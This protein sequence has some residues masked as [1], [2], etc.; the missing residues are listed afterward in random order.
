MTKCTSQLLLDIT[1]YIALRMLLLGLMLRSF[2]VVSLPS[3]FLLPRTLVDSTIMRLPGAL[4]DHRMTRILVFWDQLAEHLVAKDP[5]VVNVFDGD[6]F[7]TRYP[8]L[9][10]CRRSQLPLQTPESD[11][12]IQ[13]PSAS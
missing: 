7:E 5:R 6:F 13:L 4:F 10:I 11:L 12:N 1:I 2:P 8:C 3:I 9:Y